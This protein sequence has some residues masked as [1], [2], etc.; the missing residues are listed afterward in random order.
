N[1]IE[2]FK[3]LAVNFETRLMDFA[4][5]TKI[6]DGLVV[7]K[8]PEKPIG[9]GKA[10]KAE[11]RHKKPVSAP[12]KRKIKGKSPKKSQPIKIGFEIHMDGEAVSLPFDGTMEGA[13]KKAKY[14]AKSVVATF[15]V[16]EFT[17]DNQEGVVCYSTE[18]DS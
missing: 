10:V 6:V 16:V 4:Q 14:V 11:K 15:E 9:V 13:I 5:K 2:R 18:K 1:F 3:M 12:V 17:P 8:A 7:Q